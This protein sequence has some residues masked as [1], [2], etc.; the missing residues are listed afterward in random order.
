M[1]KLATTPGI[2]PGI[3]EPKLALV[4]E[5]GAVVAAK[6]AA[7]TLPR[8]HPHRA[9]QQAGGAMGAARRERFR[10]LLSPCARSLPHG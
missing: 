8:P 1:T 6:G 4:G 10:E 3:S 9:G 7:P 5:R 2:D